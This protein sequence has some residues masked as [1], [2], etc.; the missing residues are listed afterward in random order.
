[1]LDKSSLTTESLAV[2]VKVTVIMQEQLKL[3]VPVVLKW[4]LIV[5]REEGRRD[6]K[7]Y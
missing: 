1:M 4:V 6:T 7:D 2:V 3:K 5:N